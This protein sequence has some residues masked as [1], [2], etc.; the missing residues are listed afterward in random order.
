[1]RA[2]LRVPGIASPAQLPSLHIPFQSFPL[3]D[4]HE[5]TSLHPTRGPTIPPQNPKQRHGVRLGRGSTEHG[6]SPRLSCVM[7]GLDLLHLG[8]Q[9]RTIRRGSGEGWHWRECGLGCRGGTLSCFGSRRRATWCQDQSHIPGLK[10]RRWAELDDSVGQIVVNRLPRRLILLLSSNDN[11][12][13]SII[14]LDINL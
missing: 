12:T 3:L 9:R 5:S 1:M 6:H 14:L 11:S 4:I 2:H 7:G 10:D 13:N 8:G